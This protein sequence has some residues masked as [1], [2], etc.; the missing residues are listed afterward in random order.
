VDP[1]FVNNIVVLFQVAGLTITTP[2]AAKATSSDHGIRRRRRQRSRTAEN[3]ASVDDLDAILNA[4]MQENAASAATKIRSPDLSVVV[5]VMSCLLMVLFW[6][7]LNHEDPGEI[8][9]SEAPQARFAQMTRNHEVLATWNHDPTAFT[10]GLTAEYGTKPTQLHLVESTGMYGESLIRVWDPVSGET[11]METRL[12]KQY[13]GEGLCAF[14]VFGTT[15]YIVLTYR[16]GVALIYDQRLEHLHTLEVPSTI[17]GEAWGITF[18]RDRNDDTLQ[19]YVTDGSHFLY[20]WQM[21]YNHAAAAADDAAVVAFTA[22]R[23]VGRIPVS[24]KLQLPHDPSN[25]IDKPELPRLNELEYDSFTHTI[26]ANIW[27]EPVVVRIDADRGQ[28]LHVYDLS[29]LN[30]H[31]A[32]ATQWESLNIVMNGVALVPDKTIMNGDRIQSQE[33]FITGKYWPSVYHIKV[34]E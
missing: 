4:A 5:S 6:M 18:R 34:H 8:V 7:M 10:Q 23:E 30:Y 17:K 27:F 16:E 20:V 14:D 15:Y 28:V 31:K 26:L 21:E 11:T 32:N 25:V 13:F 22:L 33:W 9:A 19:F 3:D 2:M 29:P 1:S 12:D 24:M